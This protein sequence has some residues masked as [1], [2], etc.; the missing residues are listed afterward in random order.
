MPFPYKKALV[1]GATSGIGKE[2]AQHL[3]RDGVPVIAVGRR[4]DRLE[5]L[6]SQGQSLSAIPFDIAKINEIP[7]FA[8]RLEFSQPITLLL[9][10]I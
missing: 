8:E 6:A 1:I 10:F 4:R 7:K 2:L 5:Q 9:V 3:L